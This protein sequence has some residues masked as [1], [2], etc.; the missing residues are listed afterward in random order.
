MRKRL[1]SVAYALRGLKIVF[2]QERNFQLQTISAL[3]VFGL[4]FLFPL[5]AFERIT[6]ILVIALVLLLELTNTA[7]EYTL[8]IFRPRIHPTVGIVKDIM[9][10]AVL[11]ASLAALII[12]T[13]IFLP[14]FQAYLA[15]FI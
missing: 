10:G 5:S 7:L 8:D 1:L 15:P 3:I 6:L 4:M 9:A 11:L 14:H 2:W 12:G 13:L